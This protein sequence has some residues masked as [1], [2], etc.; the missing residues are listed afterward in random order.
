MKIV[1]KTLLF[2][3]VATAALAQ[4][5]PKNLDFREGAVGEDPTGWNRHRQYKARVLDTGCHKPDARCV[6]IEAKT[7]NLPPPF[8]SFSQF[9]APGELRNQRVK[10]SAWVRMTEAPGC[11]AQLWFRTDLA[12]D[13]VGFFYNMND[14]PITSPEW[15][16]YEFVASVQPDAVKISFG[17]IL[18]GTT[19]CKVYAGD[20][21]LEPLGIL[22]TPFVDP[23][24]RTED[25]PRTDWLK[26]NALMIRTIDPADDDFADLQPLKQ[27]IGDA[28]VVQLGEQSHGDGAAFYAKERLIRFLHEQM[29]FDV[30]AWESGFYDCEEMNK[31][32]NSGMPLLEAAQKGVFGIWTRGGLLTPL[33]QYARS[34]LKTAR[35]LRQTG[36]DIQ[37]SGSNKQAFAAVL[38]ELDDGIAS[39]ADKQ[40]IKDTL[41]AMVQPPAYKPSKELERA[42]QSAVARITE[43]LRK[44][45]LQNSRNDD[46]TR[47]RTQFLAKSFENLGALAH[48][49]TQ[50]LPKQALSAEFSF[51]DI[52]MGENLI[53]LA[54][55]WYKGKKI[56]VWA[57]SMHVVRNAAA[58]DTRMDT[59]NYKEYRTMG[60]VVHESL[61]N[62]AYTI[63]FT[64]YQGRSGNPSSPSRP[65]PPP[66][67]ES[68]ETLFHA[69]GMPYALVDFRR[70]PEGHWLRSPMVM[71]PLGY[72]EM[73]SDWTANFDA[74]L[75]TDVMFPNTPAGIVPAGVKTKK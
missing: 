22:E 15:K 75:F 10:F 23:R 14:R 47:G 29:G 24:L 73:K 46:D 68:V 8:E 53:W 65:L 41:Q 37:F 61:G 30:L 27:M 31:A 67:P 25:V 28:R 40:I 63:T 35:P 62:D 69:A 45:T 43:A 16:A 64:A 49:R 51:R 20:F 60:Q 19:T 74:V 26:K 57:A 4:T 56:I 21:K 50:T 34:T 6:S 2:T 1:Q 11:K 55:D 54:N 59:L 39:S 12:G 7:N 70:L 36:F 18:S 66:E 48:L 44:R 13:A 33:F 3:A 5:L 9:L 71:R 52:K 32:I 17:L 42:L 58:I 38:D 72:S